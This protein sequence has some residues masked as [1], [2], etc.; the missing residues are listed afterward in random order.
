MQPTILTKAAE[1]PDKVSYTLRSDERSVRL[2]EEEID[3][4]N[5]ENDADLW[6]VSFTNTPRDT[7]IKVFRWLEAKGAI[8]RQTPAKREWPRFMRWLQFWRFWEKPAPVTPVEKDWPWDDYVPKTLEEALDHLNSTLP[9]ESRAMVLQAA[10]VHEFMG[11]VHHFAGMALRNKWGLWFADS[12]LHMWFRDKL[13]IWHADDMSSL[14]Y[15]GLFHRVRGTTPNYTEEVA[16]YKEHWRK[17]G[18]T[19]TPSPKFL[20]QT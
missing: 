4:F 16:R 10:D 6:K 2:T 3:Q 20:R 9:P 11:Q 1:A 15:Y 5:N 7:F 13:Q 18:I 19:E 17:Q 12:P 14:I 8:P